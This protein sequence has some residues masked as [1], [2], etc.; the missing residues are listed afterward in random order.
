MEIINADKPTEDNLSKSNS[1]M[2]NNLIFSRQETVVI[3]VVKH[4]IN[5]VLIKGLKKHMMIDQFKFEQ[6]MFY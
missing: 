4:T 6:T 1:I 5:D 2:G 3:N